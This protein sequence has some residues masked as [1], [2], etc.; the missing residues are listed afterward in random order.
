METTQETQ[1][2]KEETHHKYIPNEDR[3]EKTIGCI[4]IRCYV[5]QTDKS[6]APDQD[7]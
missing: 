2:Q 3:A 7:L 5:L 1:Q 4:A 6:V